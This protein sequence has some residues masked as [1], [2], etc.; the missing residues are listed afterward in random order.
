MGIRG[1]ALG[2]PEPPEGFCDGPSVEPLVGPELLV[3]WADE[4][5]RVLYAIEA[6]W[7]RVLMPDDGA[8][9][10]G[11]DIADLPADEL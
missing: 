2:F 4:A 6:F 5:S 11:V 7:P 10:S 1:F 8:L 3:A 9:V